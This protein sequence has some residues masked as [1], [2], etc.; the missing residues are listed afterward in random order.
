MLKVKWTVAQTVATDPACQFKAGQPDAEIFRNVEAARIKALNSLGMDDSNS[1]IFQISRADAAWARSKSQR[2]YTS[3][4]D[5]DKSILA[6][7]E[8]AKPRY[9]TLSELNRQDFGLNC[10]RSNLEMMYVLRGM[11]KLKPSG[12]KVGS[13]Y[14]FRY[15][16]KG[17]MGLHVVSGVKILMPD[18]GVAHLYYDPTA[19]RHYFSKSDLSILSH[20]AGPL[21]AA[22][23]ERFANRHCISVKGKQSGFWQKDG[24]KIVAYEYILGEN[25]PEFGIGNFNFAATL[26]DGGETYPERVKGTATFDQYHKANLGSIAAL[27]KEVDR[28][29]SGQF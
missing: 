26:P 24:E 28:I 23:L 4:S 3:E 13:S 1:V 14:D 15:D 8:G 20:D 18:G 7:E 27:D 29:Y 25:W 16:I 17:R 19:A 12:L 6:I 10:A 5:I 22:S 2:S 11:E 9:P 21:D